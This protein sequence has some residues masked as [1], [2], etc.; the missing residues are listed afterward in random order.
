MRGEQDDLI[1]GEAGDEV[2]E[3]HALLGVKPGRGLVEDEDVRVVEDRLRDAESLLHA[4]RERAD[5]AVLLARK[6][7]PVEKLKRP[8][9]SGAGVDALE[10]RHVLH[11]VQGGELRVVAE[12]LR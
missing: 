5:A 10:C 12:V 3:A 2:A 8:G 4:S 11:E 9:A 6:A 1:R 7:D